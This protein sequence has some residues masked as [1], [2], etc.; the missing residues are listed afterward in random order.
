MT[1]HYYKQL[2]ALYNAQEKALL[3]DKISIGADRESKHGFYYQFSVSDPENPGKMIG[4]R[5][6][7]NRAAELSNVPVEDSMEYVGSVFAYAAL[8]PDKMKITYT[9]IKVDP[10]NYISHF[11]SDTLKSSRQKMQPIELDLTDYNILA[12]KDRAAAEKLR[13]ERQKKL[14]EDFRKSVDKQLDDLREVNIKDRKD[15]KY[16]HETKDLESK[17]EFDKKLNEE[18]KKIRERE[19]KEKISLEAEKERIR[20]EQEEKY[21]K[22]AEAEKQRALNARLDLAQEGRDLIEL[23]NKINQ[24][25]ESLFEK[26]MKLDDQSQLEAVNLQKEINNMLNTSLKKHRDNINKVIAVDI[27][28]YDYQENDV[29]ELKGGADDTKWIAD[30]KKTASIKA[31]K[32]AEAEQDKHL[33]EEE[34]KDREIYE[35]RKKYVAE[36]K[37]AALE[38]LKAKLEKQRR[39]EERARKAE[40]EQKKLEEK[41]YE[42]EKQIKQNERRQKE[43]DSKLEY[44]LKTAKEEIKN[45]DFNEEERKSDYIDHNERAENKEKFDEINNAVD[46]LNISRTS[47][48]SED[49]IDE[50]GKNNEQLDFGDGNDKEINNEFDTMKESVKGLNA[51]HWFKIGISSHELT[52]IKELNERLIAV[53]E[54]LSNTPDGIYDTEKANK[55]RTSLVRQLNKACKEYMAEKRKNGW[56]DTS[57]DNWLPRTRMGKARFKAVRAIAETCDTYLSTMKE[58][59]MLPPE[60]ELDLDNKVVDP[61]DPKDWLA[62][63]KSLSH[64]KAPADPATATKEIE[65]CVLGYLMSKSIQLALKNS[66]SNDAA[67][68]HAMASMTFNENAE[69]IRQSDDFKALMQG[70][71]GKDW[72]KTY[73]LSQ[74]ALSHDGEAVF[75]EY[76]NGCVGKKKVAQEEKKMTVKQRIAAINQKIADEK[77]G[78]L[79]PAAK[80]KSDIKKN[81]G[82]TLKDGNVKD[83]VANLNKNTIKKK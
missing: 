28:K 16:V 17:I 63:L 52:R 56:G 49:D 76:I 50:I 46:N 35:Q 33:A 30:A 58:L 62:Q 60:N 66:K 44:N 54:Q 18:I 19:E 72:S 47:S 79:K 8:H 53:T 34:K 43:L 13:V 73:A 36:K 69:K 71:D 41:R 37:K 5:E 75:T 40:E 67:Y 83:K 23:R 82:G 27:K 22:F 29:K 45:D 48:L 64:K 80:N 4:M 78:L 3:N 12:K 38:A 7:M 70:I 65:D 57:K 39:D 42:V 31:R 25:L 68:D 26:S 61:M 32:A 55:L 14:F 2:G 11:D 10:I 1:D 20:K 74:K 59:D 24:K 51:K 9:P 21:K 77:A 15:M 81:M 6:Y